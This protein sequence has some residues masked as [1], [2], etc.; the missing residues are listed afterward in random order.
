VIAVVA[1][2]LFRGVHRAVERVDRRY[3]GVVAA[4]GVL[5]VISAII[6][7]IRLA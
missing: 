3:P 2:A 5:V 4:I 7:L 1:I 6:K